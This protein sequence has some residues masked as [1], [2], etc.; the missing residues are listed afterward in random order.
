MGGNFIPFDGK[1]QDD[2]KESEA[3]TTEEAVARTA[4]Y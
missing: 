4:Q 1:R 2:F 3:T